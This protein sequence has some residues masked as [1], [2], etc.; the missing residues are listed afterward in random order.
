MV[1]REDRD[2][3]ALRHRITRLEMLTAVALVGDAD[4]DNELRYFLRRYLRSPKAQEEL[5]DS[6]MFSD[7]VLRLI[8]KTDSDKSQRYRNEMSELL[9]R[10]QD[11]EDKHR[12]SVEELRGTLG[13][14]EQSVRKTDDEQRAINA[15]TH[16]WLAAQ[17]LGADVS[18]LSLTRFVPLRI[19]LSDVPSTGVSQVSEAVDRLLNSFDFAI[20]DDFPAIRG[21][22]YKKW[23]AKTK[24][25]V[26]QPEVIERLQ[27]LERGIE[28]QGLT[29]PQAE[30]DAIQ[31]QAVQNLIKS[32]ENVPTAAMQVG[33][34]LIIKKTDANGAAIAV[35]TLTQM[36]LIHLENNQHLLSSPD[37]LLKKLKKA[38]QSDKAKASTLHVEMGLAPGLKSDAH[39][40]ASLTRLP[41]PAPNPK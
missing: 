29:K 18:S 31:A 8:R 26:T 23:F 9:D 25:A 10:L 22:W 36:E 37:N 24:D 1:A 12:A 6:A 40:T 30:A 4:T 7:L 34:V 5:Y 32:L 21:S 13:V 39:D 15:T 16:Q 38:C 28:L 19:Y 41:P 35:R 14:I 33:S 17:S 20:S 27:K 11:V 3:D 2:Y